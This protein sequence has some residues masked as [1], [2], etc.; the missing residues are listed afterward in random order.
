M[1]S[2]KTIR[3]LPNNNRFYILT[4][5]V[6]LSVFTLCL[7]RI[8]IPS[9]Q[10]FY[11]RTEQVYGFISVAFLYTALIISPIEKV[12]GKR[13]SVKNLLF[14]RRAI[15]VSAAYFALL[16]AAVAL[17]GQFGG[18]GGLV[19]LPDRFV[20]ALIFGVTALIV[21]FLMAATSFDKV[22]KFMTFRK[23]KWLH[24]F[25]YM[26]SVL[27][28][29]HVWMIGTHVAYD[30]VQLATFI[31]L[32]LLFGLEAWTIMGKFSE[33]HTEFK[34]K[35][36]FWILVLSMWLLS[37]LLLFMLPALV[38]NYHSEHYSEHGGSSQTHNGADHE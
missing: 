26:G 36:Y 34:S 15:G 1:L 14:A 30:W 9:D 38:K 31:P 21:L 20:W 11:I 37:S 4:F 17:W 16:H 33:K 2:N 12:V 29:L 22:I 23:W 32:S 6:L 3:N 35:D 27:I 7:L 13:E 10:L 18:F 24:R 8:Q 28:I 25:V 19:L 5:S